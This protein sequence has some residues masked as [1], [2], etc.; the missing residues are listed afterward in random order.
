MVEIQIVAGLESL[1]EA[2]MLRT[3]RYMGFG[4]LIGELQGRKELKVDEQLWT[5][6]VVHGL[7][8]DLL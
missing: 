6:E 1:K 7:H 5:S 2:D 8:L 3:K 4:M